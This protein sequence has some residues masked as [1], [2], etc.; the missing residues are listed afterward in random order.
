[1]N[2]GKEMIGILNN[3]TP[4]SE[5]LRMIKIL[6]AL[7]LYLFLKSFH[8]NAPFEIIIANA[9]KIKYICSIKVLMEW[10]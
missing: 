7:V 3:P 8:S 5:Q 9:V 2:N 10:L 6:S 4:I 1:M